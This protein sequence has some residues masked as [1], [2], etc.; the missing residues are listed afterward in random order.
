MKKSLATI[1]VLLALAGSALCY[2]TDVYAAGNRS[3]VARGHKKAAAKVAMIPKAYYQVSATKRVPVDLLYTISLQES[4][5]PTNRGRI[6]PWPW[7]VNWKGVGYRF[8]TRAEMYQFCQKLLSKGY[9]SFDVGASQV[10]WLYHSDRFSGDLWAATD[11]WTNLNAAADYIK[12]RY[13]ETG[14]WWLAAGQY[15]SP[16]NPDRAASYMRSVQRKW[17]IVHRM[18]QEEGQS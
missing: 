3:T 15:H 1:S 11:P 18:L 10:N 17:K 7:T 8:R 9:R 12:E 13:D 5:I 14:N 4:Q 6:V 16:G 2:G